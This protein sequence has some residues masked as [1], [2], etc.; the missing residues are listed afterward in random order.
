MGVPKFFRWVSERYPLCSQLI[1]AG[2][3]PAFDA[4][5]L[6]ANGI[7]HNCSHP[8]EGTAS[9]H[10][11]LTPAQMFGAMFAYIEGLFELIQP[12]KLFF[13]VGL[14]WAVC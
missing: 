8:S 3:I 9:L 6:D 4:L 2:R 11:R 14:S 12:Q 13:I 1:T 7:I 5:Y 10:Q